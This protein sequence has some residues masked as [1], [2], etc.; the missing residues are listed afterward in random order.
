MKSGILIVGVGKTGSHLA[1]RLCQSWAVRLVDANPQALESPVL[2]GCPY[3]FVGD[4]TSALVLRKAGVAHVTTLVASTS[5]DEVNL[6]VLRLARQEFGLRNLFGIMQNAK[7]EEAY[8]ALDARVVDRHQSCS[9]LL[10]SRIEGRRVATNIGLGEGEIIEVE[11]MPNSSV[12][13]QRL[14]ELHPIRWLVGAVYRAGELIVPHGDTVLAAG[15]RVLLVGDPEILSSIATHIGSG[16]SKFPLHYGSKIVIF[17]QDASQNLLTEAAYLLQSTAAQDVEVILPASDE[18]TTEIQRCCEEVG[19]EVAFISSKAATSK[20]L[21]AVAASRDMGLLLLSPR[22]LSPLARVGLM[23]SVTVRLL[24]YVASPT[25]ICRG[26]MP[27]D[28]VL[29]VLA[30]VTF[31]LTAAQLAI[32]VMR[33]IGGELHLVVVRQPTLVVGKQIHVEL[34]DKQQ[35][36]ERLARM[37]HVELKV[38]VIEGNPIHAVLDYAQRFNLVVLPY[39]RNRRSSLLNPDVSQNLLH[40]VSCS[41]LVMPY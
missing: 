9:A 16:E 40:R 23:R 32:D 2:N 10:E 5:Q 27:Y 37:Y 28:K 7:Y 17:A 41:A 18:S 25:L 33:T 11:V 1:Q 15:D 34:Q 3:R 14:S 39:K 29:L 35:E 22:D 31:P 21:T 12:I 36:I 38:N 30:E 19:A 8:R 6:E 13:G 20:E 24:D 26:A 4:G